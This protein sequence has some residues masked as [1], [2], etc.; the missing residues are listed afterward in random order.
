[1]S[2][3][4]IKKIHCLSKLDFVGKVGKYVSDLEIEG[5]KKL[6]GLWISIKQGENLQN[7]FGDSLYSTKNKQVYAVLD[8]SNNKPRFVWSC[9]NLHNAQKMADKF[10]ANFEND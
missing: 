4:I 5:E 3:L 2:N 6:E 1:M 8:Y 9:V 7:S 10:D